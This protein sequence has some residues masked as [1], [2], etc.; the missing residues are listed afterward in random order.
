MYIIFPFIITIISRL[1]YSVL[2]ILVKATRTSNPSL[3]LTFVPAYG[4]LTMLLLLVFLNALSLVQ[5]IEEMSIQFVF[6]SGFGILLDF[7][8]VIVT[9]LDCHELK[10]RFRRAE[11][12]PRPPFLIGVI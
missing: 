11:D 12:M 6:N 8:T 4:L 2:Y 7:C 5:L 9:L 3:R 1:L 10:V